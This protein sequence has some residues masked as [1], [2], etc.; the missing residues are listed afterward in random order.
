MA[1]KKRKAKA[2][3]M[4]VTTALT[5]AIGTVL[6]LSASM[7]GGADMRAS[8]DIAPSPFKDRK[9]AMLTSLPLF[10]PEAYDI[11]DQLAATNYHPLGETLNQRYALGV[12]D[13]LEAGLADDPE[14]LILAQARPFTPDELVQFDDWLRAGGEALVFA[15][16]MLHWP[17]IFHYGDPRRPEGVTLL[18]PLFAHWGLEQRIDENQP[19][20][21]WLVRVDS[22][23]VPVMQAGHFV[24]QPTDTDDSCTVRA[25][26]LIAD[27]RVGK[28][29]VQVI[30]DAEMLQPQYFGID[31]DHAD[32]GH[33]HSSAELHGTGAVVI[34]WIDAMLSR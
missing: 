29:R 33:T 4:A 8:L 31:S 11:A 20:E 3:V 16:P 9:V 28:G 24:I 14:L 27:C 7:T 34:D 5:V 26:G 12:H 30:A 22:D 25:S 19:E 17:S 1:N 13:V 32:P 15:D 18:S 6:G 21:T 10:T 2:A 23:I